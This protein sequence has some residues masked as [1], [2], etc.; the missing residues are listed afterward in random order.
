MKDIFWLKSTDLVCKTCNLE[1]L[2]EICVGHSDLQH[3][4][5]Q[6]P[7]CGNKAICTECK[8]LQGDVHDIFCD[9]TE[10]LDTDDID[11]M[12]VNQILIE[13]GL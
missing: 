4:G 9:L 13:Y 6:C 7:Y 5:Y 10:S 11:G 3:I 1:T 12:E 8:S 2:S